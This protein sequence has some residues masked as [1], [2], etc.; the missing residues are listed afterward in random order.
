[1]ENNNGF[2][3]LD[4]SFYN[5]E[6][7]INNSAQFLQKMASRRSVRDFRDQAVPKEVVENIVKVAALAPSGANKQP[8][9]FVLIGDPATKKSIRIAAEKEEYEAYNGKMP[10]SWLDDLKPF[11]TD[12]QKPFLETAPWLIVVFKKSYD[13]DETGQKLKNY[14]V[15][16]SVG[17]ACGILISAIHMAGLVTLTHTPSPMDF[18]QKILDRPANE[19][20]FLLLPVG[21]PATNAQVPNISKKPLESTMSVV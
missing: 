14:Y 11:G 1:M 5:A 6:E 15:S 7:V 8:W 9:H 4:Y 17:I 3:D 21:Y 2:I 16:E 12:W 19:K 18:L 10:G 13:L 20:P